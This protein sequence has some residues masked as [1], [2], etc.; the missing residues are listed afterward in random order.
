[1]VV[2]PSNIGEVSSAEASSEQFT[3]VASKRFHRE[4]FLLEGK[5]TS[6]IKSRPTI[7]SGIEELT[8]Y[9][10]KYY[11]IHWDGWTLVA[12]K[13]SQTLFQSSDFN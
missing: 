10:P 1:M 8:A 2:P 3:F 13:G 4:I 11:I 7:E 6:I 12:V 9:N 5:F